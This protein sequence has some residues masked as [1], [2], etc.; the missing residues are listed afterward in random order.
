M[1]DASQPSH[2]TF[3]FY[4]HNA[5][6]V[7]FTGPRLVRDACPSLGVDR[8]ASPDPP[9][10]VVELEAGQLK[11]FV[12]SGSDDA[13]YLDDPP[14]SPGVAGR[15][16]CPR[17]GGVIRAHRAQR[18]AGRNPKRSLRMELYATAIRMTRF[19]RPG[20]A[21]QVRCTFP[22]AGHGVRQAA[23]R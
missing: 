3:T 9:F 7:D 12:D 5:T 19:S 21:P 8:V 20:G 11:I 6:M 23:P 17:R 10:D 2:E 1:I 13:G 18:L 22:P 14:I 16:L 15:G 4:L